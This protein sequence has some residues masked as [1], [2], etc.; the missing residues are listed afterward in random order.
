[1]VGSA[2]QNLITLTDLFFLGR[3]GEV[4]LGAIGLVGTFYMTVASIGYGFSRGGQI[5]IARRA[6]EERWG[7]IGKIAQHMLA[8]ELLLASVLFVLVYFFAP[9]L[10][11]IWV[12]SDAVYTAC[13]D[14]LYYRSPGIFL[15]YI[16]VVF[17]S[18]YTGVARTMV[19]VYNALVLGVVNL[20]LNY[21]LIFGHRGMPEMGIGGAGLA[22]T[23][24][25]GLALSVFLVFIALDKDGCKYELF[26]RPKFD[27][28]ILNKQLKL[29][30]P[31]VLQSV[32]GMGSWFVFFLVI[33]NIGE[34]ALAISNLLRAI[35]LVFVIPSWGLAAGVN[36]IGST[37]IGQGKRRLVMP[38][39]ART[40][41]LSFLIT[42]G[43]T[44]MLF[45][46][47]NIVLRLGTDDY[48][49]IQDAQH[50]T[51]LLALI[52]LTSSISTIYFNGLVGTGAT[53][54]TLRLQIFTAVVYMTYTVVIVRVSGNS[55]TAVWLAEWI[56]W[57]LLFVLSFFYLKT[58]RWH[59]IQF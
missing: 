4:E 57:T 40:A 25:E 33:E 14:Y 20:I 50:L 17:I 59:R 2:V 22:S 39:I 52:L 10:F 38:A 53:Q 9:Y 3:V 37:L 26:A 21:L 54:M 34:R 7:F 36:T 32:V 15:S 19:I 31:I 43:L 58:K 1:M 35:F 46:M 42:T 18:M 56:Y 24:A 8:F 45:L 5:L 47:P 6:G 27:A 49:L 29:A 51:W 44:L 12:S 13:M 48:T 28:Q 23:L 30:G 16:G 41:W 55:L 11:K